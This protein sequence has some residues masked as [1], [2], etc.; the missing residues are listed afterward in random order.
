MSRLLFLFLIFC[1]FLVPVQAQ[2]DSLV[3]Y[4]DTRLTVK[5]IT[6][7]D[8]STY[9][10]DPDFNY[11]EKVKEASWLDDVWAWFQNIL[12]RIFEWVFGIDAAVG[13]LA[14]FL[15]L[16]PY[17]LLSFLIFLLI[18]FFINANLRNQNNSATNANSVGLS[19][20]ENI[21]KNEN[22]DDLIANAVA[23]K[24]YRLAIRYSYLMILKLLTD[25]D[26]IQWELQKTNS[27]Y[28]NELTQNQ[29]KTPFKASTRLYEY[30]WYGDFT[31]DEPKYQ[32]AAL[33]FATLKKSINENS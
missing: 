17:L 25:K 32:K 18:R 14:F 2:Q 23:N 15:K 10:G 11:E 6:K 28:L 19:E 5:E 21:I 13:P 3:R 16:L 29:L 20:E 26:M 4:D 33:A 31:I 7:D 12:K 22:I 24:E 30:I 27:D 1:A 8:L 9:Q